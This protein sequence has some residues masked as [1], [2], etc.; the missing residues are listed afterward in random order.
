MS[1]LRRILGLALWPVRRLLDP[2]F[3]DVNRR[4]SATKR[5][6][7]EES[8]RTRSVVTEST[9]DLAGTLASFASANTESMTFVGTQLRTFE[10]DLREVGERLASVEARVDPRLALERRVDELVAGEGGELDPTIA[11]LL[12]FAESHEGFAAREQLWINPPISVRYEAGGAHLGHVNERIVEVPYAYRAL[13]RLRRGARILDF[14]STESTVAL[15]LASMGYEAVALDLHP[16]PFSHPNLTVVESRLETWEPEPQSFD[17][18]L[19]IST[20]EHVG[21]GWYGDE[22]QPEGGDRRALERL[23][24]WLKPDGVIVLTVPYGAAGT[25]EVQ[26]TYDEQTLDALFD[27]WTI[28][29]RTVAVQEESGMWTIGDGAASEKAVAMLIARPPKRD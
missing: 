19:C 3:A 26:R 17:A 9:V 4:I 12:N 22:P 24:E 7:H 21:L 13:G 1:T 25:D 20:I 6:V 8:G 16:Y 15:S 28:E 11:R 10:Q 2:R 23:G 29:D 5:S 18:I 27:G 14:G